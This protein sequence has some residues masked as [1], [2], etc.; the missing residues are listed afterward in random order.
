M[1]DFDDAAKKVHAK[2]LHDVI[3]KNNKEI[4]EMKVRDYEDALMGNDQIY[5]VVSS[6]CLVTAYLKGY[7]EAKSEISDKK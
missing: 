2:N 4:L 7:H 1:I 5:Q 6:P 3:E